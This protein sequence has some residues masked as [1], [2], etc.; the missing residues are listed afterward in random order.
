[1]KRQK[2]KPQ[3]VK[4]KASAA[5][6]AAPDTL[7]KQ[8]MN[9]RDFMSNFAIGG[10][11]LAAFAGG[12]WYL[13]SDVLADMGDQ[14]M[15]LIGN[16]VPTVVQ[17]HDP[18]CPSCRALLK[19]S[20]EAMK[21]FEPGELQFVIAGLNTTEGR[22]LADRYRVGKVTLLLMDGKGRRLKTIAG[23]TPS[24]SLAAMF[25]LHVPA[26]GRAAG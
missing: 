8:G 3:K 1:M 18:S 12:G 13:A 14:D 7:P 11:A 16:G 19:E 2:R 26:S 9:R 4:S 25:R 24:A 17:V 5:P 6:S 15:S 21:G 10:I 20:R 23:E 22:A